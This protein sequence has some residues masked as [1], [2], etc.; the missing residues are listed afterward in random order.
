MPGLWSWQGDFRVTKSSAVVERIDGVVSE[1]II[2]FTSGTPSL[3][4][5]DNTIIG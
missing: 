1:R 3:E 2:C 4:E 5:A